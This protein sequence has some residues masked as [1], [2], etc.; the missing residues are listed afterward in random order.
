MTAITV[1][2]LMCVVLVWLGGIFYA[3]RRGLNE[4]ITG[5]SSIDQRLARLE[6]QFGA[7]PAQ[8]PE[9]EE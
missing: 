9:H 6:K 8:A 4:L 3:M 7:T 1:F 5:L 2:V